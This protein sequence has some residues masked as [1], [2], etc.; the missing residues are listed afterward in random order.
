VLGLE[1]AEGPGHNKRPGLDVEK[2]LARR[3]TLVV[4]T[5]KPVPNCLG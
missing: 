5:D 2:L 3:D 1:L 4:V